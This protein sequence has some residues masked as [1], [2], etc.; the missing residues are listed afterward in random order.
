[1]SSNQFFNGNM[2]L[3]NPTSTTDPRQEHTPEF[4]EKLRQ[5][6]LRLSPL[7]QIT[8]GRPHPEFPRTLLGFWLLTESQL[9][10]MADFYHQR[11][12][13]RLTSHYPCPVTWRDDLA[14]E[15]KRRKMGKFIGLRGCDTP[16]VDQAPHHVLRPPPTEEEIVEAARQARLAAEEDEMWRRKLPWYS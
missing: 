7:V 5:M 13:N 14:M 15:E 11:R 12:R 10:S 1:M 2:P 9:D 4:K 6:G 8:T 16:T 3:P